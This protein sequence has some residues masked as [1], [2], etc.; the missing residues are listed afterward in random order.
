MEIAEDQDF[1]ARILAELR[2]RLARRYGR[3]GDLATDRGSRMDHEAGAAELPWLFRAAL[4]RMT[5]SYGAE[6]LEARLDALLNDLLTYPEDSQDAALYGYASAATMT[7][8][9]RAKFGISVR[10]VRRIAVVGQWI[11]YSERPPSS[12]AEH[13]R[14]AEAW[15]RITAFRE[16]LARRRLGRD[17]LP[18]VESLGMRREV[19]GAGRPRYPAMTPAEAARLRNELGVG[20]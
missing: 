11:A 7:K 14:E 5:T 6:V 2:E 20:R 15:Q 17:R 1:D 8:A 4:S 9:F 18:A 12:E 13:E 16:G 3:D 19:S 10:D